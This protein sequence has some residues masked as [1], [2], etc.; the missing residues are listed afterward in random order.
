MHEWLNKYKEASTRTTFAILI[1]IWI[2]Q[3]THDIPSSSM[4]TLP[5]LLTVFVYLILWLWSKYGV[6]WGLCTLAGGEDSPAW[7]KTSHQYNQIHSHLP[8]LW[9][10]RLL[11]LISKV[12][13][14]E[15]WARPQVP[16]WHWLCD[17]RTSALDI[18]S[19]KTPK[20]NL[21]Q[22]WNN[23]MRESGAC[24]REGR[25][26]ERRKGGRQFSKLCWEPALPL[27]LCI[28]KV[29]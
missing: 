13:T 10:H 27:A 25:Q 16:R 26:G 8:N 12:L 6:I 19:L 29:I 21:I 1:H 14:E 18:H 9:K 5:V 7:L 11:D 17:L 4:C 22:S 15:I 23:N 20:Y 24:D 28:S 2:R 3:Q